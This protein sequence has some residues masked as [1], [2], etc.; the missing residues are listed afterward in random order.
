M[1]IQIIWHALFN[2]FRRHYIFLQVESL[3]PPR[4]KQAH[5]HR[6]SNSI[7]VLHVAV[8]HFGNAYNISNPQPAKRLLL[9]EGSS[10]G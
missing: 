10:D 2:A 3:L 7:W 5:Q 8:S 4:V 9:A 6:F 1:S